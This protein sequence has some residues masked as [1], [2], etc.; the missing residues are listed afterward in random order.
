MAERIILLPGDG[1]GPE[2]TEQARRVLEAAGRKFG[3]DLEF[4]THLIGGASID[5]HGTPLRDEV[6]EA[7]RASRAVLLGAVGGPKW[8]DMPVDVR[9]EKGLLGI[10]KAL[11]LFANLRPAAVFPALVEA[12]ALRPEIVAGVDMLVVRELTGGI[13][14]GEPRGREGEPGSRRALNA[15][16]YD[17]HEIARITRVA[18]EQARLRRRHV[19]H[20][21]KANVLDVSQLWVE[22][23]DEVARDYPDVELAH[24]LVDSCAMLLVQEPGR[25][26]VIVTGN[27]F[28]DILSDEAAMITGSLGMLPSASLAEGG[29]GLFEPVHGSAPDIAGKDLANPLAAIGSVAMLLESAFGAEGGAEAAAAVR[30]AVQDVLDAGH[31]SGDL[32]LPG[33]TRETVGC[34]RMGELVLE[35][36]ERG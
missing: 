18:F 15:M 8:D 33:E 4:E 24:Q 12:S 20:V 10:R 2:V 22:V 26:D 19:T 29:F 13:Y 31:R 23:V 11:G 3:L 17:E 5:A 27:L 34:Q 25:F 30:K 28:G 14:F 9:P 32:L 7:C 21:H 16:V 35:A 6:V 36:L 1:I